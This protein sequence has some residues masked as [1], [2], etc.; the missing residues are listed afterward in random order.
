LKK[1]ILEENVVKLAFLKTA[2]E[3]KARHKGHQP[4]TFLNTW[5]RKTKLFQ[6]Q[7]KQ[8]L[9]HQIAELPNVETVWRALNRH[10]KALLE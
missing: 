2:F 7:W 1:I 3:Q 6:T 5:N 10:F 8:Y 4:D 9:A